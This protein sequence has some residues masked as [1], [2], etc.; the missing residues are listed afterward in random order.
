VLPN[1]YVIGAAKCGTSSLHDYLDAH[2]EVWMSDQKELHFFVSD[3]WREKQA[4]YESHFRDSPVRGESSPTYSMYPYLPSTAERMRELTPDARFIYLV[5]DPIERAVANYVELVAL[6]HENRPIAEALTDFA[7]PANPHL[8]PSRYA[9][10][11]ERFIEQ[12]GEDRVLVIEQHDLRERRAE[13]LREIFAFLGVDPTFTSDRFLAEHNTKSAKVRYNDLGFWLV[14]RRIFVE[15]NGPFNTGPLRQP[16][17]SLLSR[18]IDRVL[19]DDVREAMAENLR[20]EVER[21]RTLTGLRLDR[22][23]SAPA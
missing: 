15:K 4:W 22:W 14:R 5:R 8:C 19:S 23:E 1:L 6:R 16:L 9:S 21:L 10:Q 18:P 12:F 11:L 20:P 3:D 2:P 17:R 7:D 13:T